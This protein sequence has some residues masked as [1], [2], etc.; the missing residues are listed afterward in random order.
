MGHKVKNQGR[1]PT[2]KRKATAEWLFFDDGQSLA[3]QGFTLQ[4]TSAGYKAPVAA[5]PDRT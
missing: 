3:S 2:R 1:S 5:G 4:R